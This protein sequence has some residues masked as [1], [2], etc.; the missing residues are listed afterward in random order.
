[1][2]S[3][4]G[5]SVLMLFFALM[6]GRSIIMKRKGI[7][8]LVI[9]QKD[10]RQLPSFLFIY[11][12]FTYIISSNCFPLPIPAFVNRFFWD[13]EWLRMIGAGL[14]MLGHVG[15]II[16]FVS[17]GNSFRVGI[18]EERAGA[19][20][21]HGMYA[22]SRNPMYVS[23]DMLFCGLF[24]IFP[25]PGALFVVAMI[26]VGFHRQILNEENFCRQ[27]YGEAYVCYCEKVRRYF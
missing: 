27:H 18:D 1:M 10:R 5:F 8:V 6:I 16:S 26:T 2:L 22:L 19:L 17:F 11:A 23:L 24:L 15:F 4:I 9:G 13:A 7:T 14:C 25:N 12:L 20:V 3:I 21:T